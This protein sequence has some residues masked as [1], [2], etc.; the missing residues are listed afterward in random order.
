M[1]KK[2]KLPIP[3]IPGLS[4][5]ML[6]FVLEFQKETDRGS[7]LAAAAFADD[8]MEAMLRARFA[9]KEKIVDATL[10]DM[11][12]LSS[13]AA[14]SHV[15]YLLGIIGPVLYDGLTLI[16]RIR[17]EFAHSRTS[18]TFAEQPIADWCDK[19]SGKVDWGSFPPAENYSPRT[20]FIGAAQVMIGNL[21]FCAR[22]LNHATIAED[23]S[24]L[25]SAEQATIA[26]SGKKETKP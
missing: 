18:I 14:R 10:T 16:R 17:N 20:L 12:P 22:S 1:S 25:R 13:M 5:E 7:A 15:L 4:G 8:L 9:Q 6:Q 19:L 2:R 23:H 24:S 21:S 11:G 26:L 3:T